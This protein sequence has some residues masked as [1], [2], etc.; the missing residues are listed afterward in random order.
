MIV[1]SVDEEE[2]AMDLRERLA[3]LEGTPVRANGFH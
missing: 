3:G 1:P 2:D